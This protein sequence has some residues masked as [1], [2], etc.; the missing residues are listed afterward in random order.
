[1]AEVLTLSR[2]VPVRSRSEET[3]ERILDAAESLVCK[4]QQEYLTPSRIAKEARMTIHELYRFYQDTQAIFDGVARRHA[5]RFREVLEC[6]V[7]LPL[8]RERKA[9]TASSNPIQFLEDVID[10][11]V[12]YLDTNPG[13]R[14]IALGPGTKAREASPIA[15]FAAV[16][17][18]FL[19]ERMRVPGGAE[20]DLTLFVSSRAC[21]GLIA[22]AFE[23]ETKGARELV[24]REMKRLLAGYLFV[25]Q[26]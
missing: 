2:R 17:R 3:T 6:E 7:L 22:A 26:G 14:A 19:V 1:M 24:I 23:Q 25:R 11:Y 16:L 5:T 10:A 4:I 20:M 21:E 13:L 8:E 12:G 9:G 18:T 15:G